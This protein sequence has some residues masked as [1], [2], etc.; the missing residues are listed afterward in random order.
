MGCGSSAP[1]LSEEERDYLTHTEMWAEHDLIQMGLGGRNLDTVEKVIAFQAS[2]G[3]HVKHPPTWLYFWDKSDDPS[4]E[5]WWLTK[6]VGSD[7][8]I[9]FAPGAG[10]NVFAAGPWQAGPGQVA[11]KTFPVHSSTGEVLVGVYGPGGM[12]GN[13]VYQE[14]PGHP[15]T[16]GRGAGRPVYKRI[17]PLSP[18]EWE[19]CRGRNGRFPPWLS[20]AD[21]KAMEAKQLIK[22]IDKEFDVQFEEK[23][24]FIKE[25]FC[26]FDKDDDGTIAAKDLGTV[27]GSLCLFP[28]PTEAELADMI[29]EVD[30][31]G[32]STIDFPEFLTLTM[33]AMKK[34]MGEIKEETLATDDVRRVPTE[35]RGG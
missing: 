11:A 3:N 35:V 32:A 17:R 18:D 14:Q 22:F 13:G 9:V 28:A 24:A 4:W 10:T 2:I 34:E 26:Q 15:H 12:P 25:A 23:I 7:D 6:S 8:F 27:M 16:S 20:E 31:D 5:G 29:D 19:A 21:R 1:A 33:R 30:A